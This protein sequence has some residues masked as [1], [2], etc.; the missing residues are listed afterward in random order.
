MCKDLFCPTCGSENIHKNGKRINADLSLTQRY[1]CYTCGVGCTNPVAP[2]SDEV[3]MRSSVPIVSRYIV[4]T[5]QNATPINVPFWNAVKQCAEY[6][7]A[8]IIV[9]P[10]RYKN[11]TSVWTKNIDSHEFWCPEVMPYLV[12]GNINLGNAL[13]I[14]NTK[15]QFTATN[16]LTS[17]ENLTGSKSGIIG[18]P[19]ISQKSVATPQYKMTK[20]LWS[21]GACTIKNYTDTKSG[22]LG[23]FNH[24]AAALMVEVADDRFHV[25]Q[26]IAMRNGS[27]CDLGMEFL[28][29]QVRPAKRPLS[30]TM[31]DTHWAKIDQIVKKT[32]FNDMIPELKPH[33]LIWHDLLDFYSRNHH[34]KD[35][36]IKDYAKHKTGQDDVQIEVIAALMAV[37]Q[38]TPSDCQSVVISS[39]HDRALNRWLIETDIR[40]DPLNKDFHTTL[41]KLLLKYM[42]DNEYRSADAFILYARS[43]LNAL[44]TDTSNVSLL[45]PDE[46]FM[47]NGVEHGL[48]GDVGTNGSKGTTKNLSKLG[49]KVT[50]GHNH[51]AE[52][53]DGCYSTGTSTGSLEYC[54]GS[55]SWS[56]THCLQYYNGKRTLIT[57]INGKWRL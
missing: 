27:F 46:S 51:T 34:H 54:S 53:V 20:M 15:V 25:R 52:I 43:F 19:R 14:V 39:N 3:T 26:L 30:L 29:D 31:G 18:H 40:K 22:H 32:T 42:K 36:W 56:N 6:Y 21:T 57:I 38:N 10:S 5:A 23:A 17:M 16:P 12:K 55:S 11:P 8:E 35:N 37:V 33:H 48:H 50:K 44:P 47:L 2:K 28:P 45:D 24:S 9:I 1:K 4:T 7:A 49:V 13:M 41:T